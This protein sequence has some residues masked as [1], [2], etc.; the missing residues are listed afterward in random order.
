MDAMVVS[1]TTVKAVG[2][3]V[4]L[5]NQALGGGLLA[6]IV[7]V[8]IDGLKLILPKKNLIKRLIPV[9]ASVL[10]ILLWAGYQYV[11]GQG[12][13]ISLITVGLT[14]GLGAIGLNEI[15][16]TAIMGKVSP[17]VPTDVQAPKA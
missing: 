5:I 4:L 9:F 1:T 16:S 8:A 3:M 7:K 15:V 2:G 12:D 17:V 11:T 14:G 10:A 13:F 6:I